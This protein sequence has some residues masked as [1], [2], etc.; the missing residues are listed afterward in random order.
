[1]GNDVYSAGPVD[2]NVRHQEPTRNRATNN[3]GGCECENCGC[4]FIGGPE[5]SICGDCFA[6]YKEAMR[7]DEQ[8]SEWH[9][10][11]RRDAF[12]D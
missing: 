5:H 7:E 1:M 4:I 9:A 3:P 11:M 6:A 2:A 10:E 8:R 12:G